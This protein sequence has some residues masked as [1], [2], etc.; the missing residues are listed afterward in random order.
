MYPVNPKK[1]LGQHFLADKN[2]AAK[3]TRALTMNGYRD[4]IEI[5][6]GTGI[7]TSYLLD[8]SNINLRLV[9]VD[10]DSVSYLKVRFPGSDAII[11]EEDFLKYPLSRNYTEPVAI[12]GNFPYNISSQIFFRILDNRHIVKEVVCMVQKEVATRIV[13]PPGSKTYGILSVL[14]QAYYHTEMLFTVPPQVFVPPPKVTSAVL[15]L[16]RRIKKDE[17]GNELQ[18]TKL[19]RFAIPD[20]NEDLFFR[21]VKTAFNQRRKMLRN[22]LAPL[23]PELQETELLS[24][25]PEQLSPAGFTELTN[26]IETKKAQGK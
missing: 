21:V 20:C 22:S 13:S 8:N 10:P 1:R 24:R 23:L 25:R 16:T 6:P 3:I 9:E 18:E 17:P 15:R 19:V 2:I 5:G 4:V 12:I 7:L 11:E 14:L 26:L